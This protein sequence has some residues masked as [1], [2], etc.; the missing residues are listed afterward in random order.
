MKVAVRGNGIAAWTAALALARQASVTLYSNGYPQRSNGLGLWPAAVE[1]LNHLGISLTDCRQLPPAA[2]RNQTGT[3]LSQAPATP[4]MQ[5]M[6]TTIHSHDLIARLQ[7]QLQA[8]N[9][10]FRHVIDPDSEQH[11]ASPPDLTILATGYEPLEPAVTQCLC[12]VVQHRLPVP[13]FETLFDDGVR[14]AAVPLGHDQTLFFAT[15]PLAQ[16]AAASLTDLLDRQPLLKNSADIADLLQQVEAQDVPLHRQMACPMPRRDQAANTLPQSIAIGDLAHP[17]PHNLAQGAAL[18]IED[19]ALL[20]ALDLNASADV[21]ARQLATYHQHREQRYTQCWR[22]TCFTDWLA[23]PSLLAKLFREGM[24][25][26]PKGV[27][28]F[29]FQQALEYSLAEPHSNRAGA[30]IDIQHKHVKQ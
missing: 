21:L 20:G 22:V 2:Y 1:H 6:V 26:V 24:A 12:G 23:S 9:L 25:F 4:R 19:A 5:R 13:A 17:L 15:L 27:N 11:A 18:A 14:F 3:W 7:Q 29:I 30:W 8:P 10:D 16:S 28:G